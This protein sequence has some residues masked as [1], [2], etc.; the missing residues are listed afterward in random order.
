MI[1]VI[2]SRHRHIVHFVLKQE[3]ETLGSVF[4]L[5]V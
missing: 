5:H 4:V 2:N 1:N 3:A